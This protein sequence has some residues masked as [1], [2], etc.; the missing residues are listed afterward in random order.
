MSPLGQAF[1]D[2]WEGVPVPIVF[3]YVSVITPRAN[4]VIID[5]LPT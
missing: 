4:R 2:G 3:L 5:V 1:S